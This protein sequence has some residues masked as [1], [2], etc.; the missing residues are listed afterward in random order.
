MDLAILETIQAGA[1]WPIDRIVQAYNIENTCPRCGQIPE[2]EW[3]EYWTCPFIDTIDSENITKSNHL[4]EKLN[5]DNITYFNR[6][7]FCEHHNEVPTA[8]APL[9][10]YNLNRAKQNSN[11]TLEMEEHNW[12]SGYYFG[13]GS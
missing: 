3:H 10:E 9:E 1:T 6:A 12:P 13:D 8:F 5:L 2:S 4:K 7:I 11:V